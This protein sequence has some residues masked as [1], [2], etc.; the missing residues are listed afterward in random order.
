VV[1]AATNFLVEKIPAS[2]NSHSVAADSKRNLIFVPQVAPN[3][4]VVGGDSTDVGA[5]I[6]GTNNGCVAVYSH[7]VRDGDDHDH[8]DH[9][10]DNH[11]HDH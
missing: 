6:C 4:V 5:G 11:D 10:G 3:T 2:S 1:D 7:Q 8:G 9:D